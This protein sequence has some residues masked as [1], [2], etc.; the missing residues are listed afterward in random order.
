MQTIT[1]EEYLDIMEVGTVEQTINTSSS[2]AL[3]VNVG[4]QELPS[5]FIVVTCDH[6]GRS[7]LAPPFFNR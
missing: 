3:V 7:S 2:L 6:T 1:T 5:R 4:T